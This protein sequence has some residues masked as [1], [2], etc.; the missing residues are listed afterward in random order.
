MKLFLTINFK[1]GLGNQLFQYCKGRYLS[2]INKIPYLLFN[3]DNYT[4]ESLD[5][6]FTLQNFNIKGREIKNEQFKNLFKPE[7]KLNKIIA[8]LKLFRIIEEAGFS[9]EEQE[10]KPHIFNSLSGYW[11]SEK[12]FAPIRTQL[13]KE[14]QPKQIPAYPEWLNR[15]E[16]VAIHVRRTDYLKEPRYGFIGINYY[17]EAIAHIK[18][19]SQNP[20]FI[21]FSD[22]MQWCKENLK[23]ANVI[24]FSAENWNKDYLQLHLISKCKHQIIANSSFS[25]WGAWL[26]ENENKMVIRPTH[27]FK[28]ENLLHEF[29]YPESWIAIKN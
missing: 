25:W 19:Q 8:S 5:R 10:Y 29:H 17:R 14:L 6:K 18:V 9:Y 16:T 11:Q 3:L 24:Y 4:N 21:I 12:Y 15:A 28:D 22:D 20:L 27:P 13:L 1:G 23:D 2:E 7:T 26:N